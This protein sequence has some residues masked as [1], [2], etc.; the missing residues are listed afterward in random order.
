LA[1]LALVLTVAFIVYAL[2]LDLRQ[3]KRFSAGMWICFEWID[4]IE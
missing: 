2:R 1:K 3:G 4:I